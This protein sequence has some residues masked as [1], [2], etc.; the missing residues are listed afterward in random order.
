M[1]FIEDGKKMAASEKFVDG[2]AN[3]LLNVVSLIIQPDP[4]TYAK[5]VY[6]LGKCPF[7]IKEHMFWRKFEMFLN[8]IYIKEEDVDK[9][10]E[11]IAS[12]GADGENPYRIVTYIDR[13]ETQKKIHFLIN[14]TRCLMTDF[15]TLEQYFRICHAIVNTL[16]E[17][18]K[19]LKDHLSEE[20][21]TYNHHVQG[22]FTNGL[23][24][25]NDFDGGGELEVQGYA[26]TPLALEVDEYAISYDDPEKY[27]NP[28]KLN[29]G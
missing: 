1:K 21:V 24:W 23:M 17:D 15:I 25:A 27:P 29:E 11:K 13:A 3:L 14:A 20:E 9:L 22:L 7:L 19:F 16:E 6:T 12:K 4:V 26:F 2:A 5:I 18:L 10:H 28:K 8:G